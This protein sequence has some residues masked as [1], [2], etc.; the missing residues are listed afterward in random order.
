MDIWVWEP[1]VSAATNIVL[2]YVAF[3]EA[4]KIM[5]NRNR[6]FVQRQRLP[7]PIC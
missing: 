1:C 7:G 5:N 3:D 4:F 2:P 6:G